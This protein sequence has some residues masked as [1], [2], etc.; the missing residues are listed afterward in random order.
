MLFTDMEG[1]TRLAQ[2][3]GDAW[4]DVLADHRRVIREEVE[5]AGGTVEVT[6]GDSFFATFAKPSDAVG[7]AGG[8]Q[9]AL[10]G[11]RWPDA[12]DDLRV[13]MGIHTGPARYSDGHW[14]GVEVHRAARIAAAAS[15]GQVI[16]SEPVRAA[17]GD[18]CVCE[19]LGSHRLR[20]LAGV[21]R[22]FHLCVDE[23]RALDFAPPRTLGAEHSILERETE[24]RRVAD[25]VERV[26]QGGRGATLVVEGPAGIGKTRLLAAVGE[27]AVAHGMA[28]FAA[29]GAELERGFPFGLVRQ[30]FDPPLAAADTASRGELLDGAA[31][32]ALGAL[33][34][35][36][37]SGGEVDT[38]GVMHGLY[39]LTAAFAARDR[40]LV[41]VDDA[42]WGDEASLRFLAY[43]FRRAESLPVLVVVACRPLLSGEPGSVLVSE[44]VADPGAELLRP[45]ALGAAAVGRLLGEQLGGPAD[46]EFAQACVQ[47][48]GGNPFLLGELAREL[49]VQ[50]IAPR[51]GE[52]S[53]V[54]ALR[55]DNVARS[56]TVRLG[57][58]GGAAGR[59]A[60]AIALLGDGADLSL[61]GE[62][63]G[64][65][66]DAA[67]DALDGLVREGV[68]AADLP[69]R[70]AHPL[71]RTA[72]EGM[73]APGERSRLHARAAKLLA[74]RGVSVERVASHLLETTPGGVS[75]TVDVLAEAAGQARAQGAPD[76]AVRLLARALSE[77]PGHAQRPALLFELGRA[78][79]EL[80]LPS[81]RAHLRAAAEQAAD[82]VLA[83]R[84]T[85]ALVWTIGP[86]A[87]S[88]REALPLIERAIERVRGLDRELALEASRR[89][90]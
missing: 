20:D 1:S 82:P 29:R 14:V 40:L 68:L 48:T 77:P 5:R 55:P 61:A 18:A 2:E 7:A 88:Q 79:R 36:P 75:R 60:P 42:Q 71:L 32:L 24:L 25:L 16:V 10:R 17:L 63:V 35:W 13:R 33:G 54:A 47:A 72:A 51:A 73:L 64:L 57:R 81:A 69:P 12:V 59:L 30:L 85:R 34:D 38:A 4:P 37:A 45:G 22:L 15:G 44:L 9:R 26:A 62:L 27:I 86:D 78:E 87:D 74:E 80:A 28:V 31:A 21:E 11:H 58:T 8:V 66:P 23:R 41:C 46:V 76:V 89:C 65:A 50:G 6:E 70:Y 83:A 90:G 3:L 49:R 56:L 53:R 19:D 84:A 67:A 39:W 52:A 43:F